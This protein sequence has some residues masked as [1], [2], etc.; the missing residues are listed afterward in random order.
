MST[1]HQLITEGA[2]H[3]SAGRLT[4]SEERFRS[5]LSLDEGNPDTI[6]NLGLVIQAQK[7]LEEAIE[8]YQQ[9]IQIKPNYPSAYINLGVALKD[10]GKIT[11]AIAALSEAIRLNPTH[12]NAL[13]NLGISLLTNGQLTEGFKHYEYRFPANPTLVVCQPNIQDKVFWQGEDI[14]DRSLLVC[15]EQGLGDA[16]QFIRYLD[17]LQERNLN[18]TFAVH[19]S[20]KKLFST[21]LRGNNYPVLSFEEV[22]IDHYAHHVSLL[23]LPHIFGTSLETIPQNIPYIQFTDPVPPDLD[24]SDLPGLKIGLVWATDPNNKPMYQQKSITATGVFKHLQPA[25]TNRATSIVSL[26]VGKAAAWIQPYLE[27]PQVYDLSPKLTDFCDTATIISQLD[28]VI[29]VDTAVAH[30]AGAMGKPVWVM[31]PFAAD[32]RWL[33]DRH[34]SPWYPTMRLFRQ[35]QRGDWA[36]ALDRVESALNEQLTMNN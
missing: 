34:D 17:R 35:A 4:E 26:Q 25:L 13:Y 14:A 27:Q 10:A 33:R 31:L 16:I 30:L 7:R 21:Y 2:E 3:Y 11:E 9:A 32:W 5:A 12:A 6:Y 15:Y 22:N 23:S 18:V 20:L 29:T 1:L 8:L 24:I 19:P 36:S 28:L